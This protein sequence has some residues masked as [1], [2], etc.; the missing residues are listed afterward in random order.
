MSLNVTLPKQT[1]IRLPKIKDGLKEGLNYSQIG[2]ACGVTER[3]IDRDMN[4]WV[5]SGLFEKWL[6]TEFVQVHY[7]MKGANISKVYDNLSRIVAR[8]VTQKQEITEDI[9]QETRIVWENK[10]PDT[11]D[12]VQST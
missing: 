11:D 5:T 9:Y 2:A 4:V 3:T 1:L 6:I 7:H 12:K 10:R 8:M